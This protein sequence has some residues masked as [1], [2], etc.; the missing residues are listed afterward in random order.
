MFREGTW[1]AFLHEQEE[2]MNREVELVVQRILK[3]E[4]VTEEL[5]KRNPIEWVRR[6]NGIR[7][8]VEEIVFCNILK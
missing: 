4:G 3:K 1:N 7:S 8:R 2:E 5:K 6:V